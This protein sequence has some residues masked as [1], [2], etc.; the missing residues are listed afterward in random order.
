MSSFNLYSRGD[1]IFGVVN[2]TLLTLFVLSTLYPFI[3]IAASSISS[4]LAVTSGDVLLLPKDITFAA[5]DR[6][7]SDPVFWTSYANTLFYTIFGTL[8]SL[9]I[10]IP[11]AYALSRKRLIGRRY[12]NFFVAFTM[13]F[14][15]GMIPFFLNIRDLGLLDSRI[16]ILIAFACT[17]FNIILLRNFFESIPE[18]FEEAAKMDGA[19]EFTLLWK[20]YI[21]LSKPALVTIALF[22]IVARWNGYFWAMVLLRDEDKIPLQV[23]LKKIIIELNMDDQFA[24]SLINSDYSFETIVAAIIVA[25]IIPVLAVYPYLQKHF[26]KGI[27]MGGV[28]E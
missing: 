21:P 15:A 10:I 5:Y 8:V 9:A 18:S 4:G 12:L 16:G 17:A 27:M 7:L 28:K 14:H 2:A 11:G 20:V 26:N 19:N 1:K 22:C 13:W 23:Y 24:S 6:V 3:Y 25:S